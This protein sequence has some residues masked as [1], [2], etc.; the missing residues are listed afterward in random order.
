MD[1]NKYIYIKS[2]ALSQ[3]K[4]N[5]FNASPIFENVVGR[6]LIRVPYKDTENTYFNGL[7]QIIFPLNVVYDVVDFRLEFANGRLVELNGQ[8]W[9]LLLIF[10]TF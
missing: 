2:F 10:G 5:N 4:E 6:L 7:Y 8:D 9:S 1:P 3:K